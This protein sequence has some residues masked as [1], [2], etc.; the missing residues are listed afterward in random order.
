MK[1]TVGQFQNE[2]LAKKKQI[3]TQSDTLINRIASLWQVETHPYTY[4]LII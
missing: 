2:L 4:W 3:Y 1:Y